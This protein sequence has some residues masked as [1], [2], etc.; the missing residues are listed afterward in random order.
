MCLSCRLSSQNLRFANLLLLFLPTQS[1]RCIKGSAHCLV[2]HQHPLKRA[3]QLRE[4]D[5]PLGHHAS[6]GQSTRPQGKP[7]CTALATNLLL[8]IVKGHMW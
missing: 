4:K 3:Q 5:A 2:L 6:P 7:R 8:L 1:Y